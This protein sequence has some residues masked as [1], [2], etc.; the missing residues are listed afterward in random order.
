[1]RPITETIE[2]ITIESNLVN[3]ATRDRVRVMYYHNQ[4]DLPCKPDP[5]VYKGRGRGGLDP[6]NH[7]TLAHIGRMILICKEA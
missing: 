2:K 3:S 6:S 1:M 5:L 7:N 4:P